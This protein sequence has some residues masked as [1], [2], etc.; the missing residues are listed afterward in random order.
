MN[1][2]FMIESDRLRNE[3]NIAKMLHNAVN[4]FQQTGLNEL[5]DKWHRILRNYVRAK[6]R[7]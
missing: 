7:T 5:A 4:L 3:E 2:L 6:T 1:F